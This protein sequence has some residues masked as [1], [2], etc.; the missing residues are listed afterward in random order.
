MARIGWTTRRAWWHDSG[1]PG[2]PIPACRCGRGD[3]A[4]T[5]RPRG[6]ESAL[7]ARQGPTGRS[8]VPAKV[9]IPTT[10][11]LPRERLESRLADLWSHRLGL[12]VAP[13]GSG[14]TTLLARFA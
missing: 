6:D 3:A 10:D 14:K 11:A 8:V 5:D 1:P 7:A 4:L 12:V 9:R 13:A 2:R